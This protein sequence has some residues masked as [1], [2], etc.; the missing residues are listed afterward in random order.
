MNVENNPITK[1]IRHWYILFI[2]GLLFIILGIYTFVTPAKAYLALSFLFSMSFLITGLGEVMFAVINKRIFDRWGW[3]L[4]FGIFNCLVGVL[5]LSRPEVSL[6]T[7]PLYL[8]FL[9]LFRSVGSISYAY[10]IKHMGFSDWSSLLFLGI[11]GVIFSF[12][13]IWNPVLGGLT[14]VSWTAL[15][16]LSIGILSVYLSFQ[17]RKFG[18]HLSH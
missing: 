9:I 2:V 8:G 5:L 16:F 11:L 18:K 15:C 7:M 10:E 13:L 6:A 14:I 4:A 17:L 1:T 3:I 12:I